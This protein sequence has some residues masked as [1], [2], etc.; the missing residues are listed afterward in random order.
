MIFMRSLVHLESAIAFKSLLNFGRSNKSGKSRLVSHATTPEQIQPRGNASKQKHLP[1]KSLFGG[2]LF[3][4][5]AQ[6]A[7]YGVSITTLPLKVVFFL[8]FTTEC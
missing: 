8:F 2:V 3:D 6:R 7:K 5:R 1:S 4:S